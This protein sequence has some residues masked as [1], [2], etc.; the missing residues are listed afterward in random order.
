[1]LFRNT[2]SSHSLSSLSKNARASKVW[3][4]RTTALHR[5]CRPSMEVREMFARQ[6]KSARP[7]NE[8]ATK[9]PDQ[10][11]ANG[12]NL[13]VASAPRVGGVDACT[14]LRPG[15]IT[16]LVEKVEKERSMVRACV[17]LGAGIVGTRVVII[18]CSVTFSFEQ[19]VST[20]IV[21]MCQEREC[22]E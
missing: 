12:N 21:P 20:L 3:K 7:E 16:W 1:M 17:T 5:A 4:R 6:V 11:K 18:L 19:M 9:S 22:F 15:R 2:D 8:N 13:S 10:N 14:A